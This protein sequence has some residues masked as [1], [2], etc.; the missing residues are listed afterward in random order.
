M[1]QIVYV[2][3]QNNFHVNLSSVSGGGAGALLSFG[4]ERLRS[5]RAAQ[6]SER[7]RYICRQPIS[8]HRGFF[9]L[10]R[11]EPWRTGDS[12]AEV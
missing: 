10:R 1:A 6:I 7:H 11:S 9:P 2:F 8:F 12:R 3:L 4:R 5:D